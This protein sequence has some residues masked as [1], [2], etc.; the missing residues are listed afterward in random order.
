MMPIKSAGS[1]KIDSRSGRKGL[2]EVCTNWTSSYQ[3]M[4]GLKRLAGRLNTGR[5]MK[6]K[7]VANQLL[8]EDNKEGAIAVFESLHPGK[9]GLFVFNNSSGHGVYAPD[10][11]IAKKMPVRQGRT[12]C[13]PPMRDGWFMKDRVL[14][15]QKMV[16]AVRAR[17]SLWA[18]SW[19]L[20]CCP[21]LPAHPL[22]LQNANDTLLYYW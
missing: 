13:E 15:E 4:D 22:S 19:K 12:K 2:V 18:V 17:R 21:S 16:D 6:G 8:G 20:R 14:I 5:T 9:Q 3:A 10:A 11:L 1:W 7:D